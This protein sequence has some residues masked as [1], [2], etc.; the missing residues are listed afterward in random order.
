MVN[1]FDLPYEEYIKAREKF[2]KDEAAAE[3]V[4]MKLTNNI[5]PCA[6]NN[7]FLSHKVYPGWLHSI[8]KQQY[9]SQGGVV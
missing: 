9:E 8:W 1:I 6:K 5:G 2:I 4:K 3:L 7:Q